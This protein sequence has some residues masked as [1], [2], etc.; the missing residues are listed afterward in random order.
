[1]RRVRRPSRPRA[2]RTSSSRLPESPLAIRADPVRLQQVFTNLLNNAIKFSPAGGEILVSAERTADTLRI[3]VADR[4]EGISK[5]VL[6]RLFERFWQADGS[7]TRKNGGLG[8]GLATVRHLLELHGA[9]IEVD[10]AGRNHGATFTVVLPLSLVIAPPQQAANADPVR[11]GTT[12]SLH[13]M[14]ALIVDDDV[15]SGVM[16]DEMLAREGVRVRTAR[17]ASQ[18]LT[19]FG[20]D[21]VDVLISDIG[22]PERDGYDLIRALRRDFPERIRSFMAIALSGYARSEDR[23]AAREASFD[24]YMS[25]PFDMRHLVTSIAVLSE[26]RRKA[27]DPGF[28]RAVVSRPN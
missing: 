5:D 22:M 13:G 19:M 14:R 9:S 16:L 18:A 12:Q 7:I 23:I 6:A 26:S 1:M 4:G 27:S 28:Q 2:S 11:A 8:L 3:A 17:N 10:S 25:N 24:L 15:E 21:A 20:E